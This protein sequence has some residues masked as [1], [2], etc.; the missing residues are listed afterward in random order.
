MRYNFFL[1]SVLNLAFFTFSCSKGAERCVTCTY[2]N[3]NGTTKKNDTNIFKT[4][5]IDDVNYS[6]TRNGVSQGPQKIITIEFKSVDAMLDQK[7]K[8]KNCK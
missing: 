3:Y 5:K 6:T 1:V 7:L 2:V 4:C 8:D